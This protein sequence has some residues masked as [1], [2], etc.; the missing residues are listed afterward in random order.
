MATIL[1]LGIYGLV[2]LQWALKM[3]E[4]VDWIRLTQDMVEWNVCSVVH[5]CFGF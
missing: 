4:G 2:E 5:K 3:Y 1:V